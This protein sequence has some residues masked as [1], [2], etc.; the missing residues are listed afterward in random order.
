[1]LLD[2]GDGSEPQVWT[3]HQ[4][5]YDECVR[6]VTEKGPKLGIRSKLRDRGPLPDKV[7]FL[8]LR[9]HQ[10]ELKG[11]YQMRLFGFNKLSQSNHT[12]N[13]TVTSIP[14]TPPILYLKDRAT[15]FWEP[16]TIWR[17]MELRVESVCKLVCNST[18]YTE[19]FWTGIGI[20]EEWGYELDKVDMNGWDCRTKSILTVPP[21]TLNYGTYRFTY[22]VRITGDPTDP[23]DVSQPFVRSVDTFV[24]ITRSPLVVMMNKGGVSM[25]TLG[26]NQTIVINPGEFSYDPDWPSDKAFIFEWYC[27]RI[28]PDNETIPRD[29]RNFPIT[30]Q[31]SNPIMSP[32]DIYEYYFDN[33]TNTSVPV[34]KTD[35]GGCFGEGPGR[36]NIT[37]GLLELNTMQLR[38]TNC[39]YRFCAVMYK[40]FPAVR[41]E[42]QWDREPR[43]AEGCMNVGVVPGSP[44]LVEIKCQVPK[45]CRVTDRGTIINPNSRV[46]L[47]GSC[48]DLC[49][50]NLL[51]S[52]KIYAVRGGVPERIENDVDY[53]IGHTKPNMVIIKQ[54]FLDFP[55]VLEFHIKMNVVRVM[56]S[57]VGVGTMFLLINTPPEG[58]TCTLTPPPNRVL[59]VDETTP[60]DPETGFLLRHGRTLTEDFYCECKDFYDQQKDK[61]AKYSFFLKNNEWGY[62]KNLKFGIDNKDKFVFPLGNWTF[63]VT[64]E[65][66]FGAARNYFIAGFSTSLPSRLEYEAWTDKKEILRASGEGDQARL[67]QLLQARTSIKGFVLEDEP[68]ETTTT[69]PEPTYAPDEFFE[70]TTMDPE[71]LARIRAEQEAKLN[72]ELTE[73]AQEI[74]SMMTQLEM[75]NTDTL[76]DCTQLFS[77]VSSIVGDGKTVDIKGKDLA[78]QQVWCI[79]VWDCVTGSCLTK[80]L[81]N[82]TISDPAEPE[83]FVSNSMQSISS[84]TAG[85]SDKVLEDNILPTDLKA[86]VEGEYSEY[87]NID[88]T[89]EELGITLEEDPVVEEEVLDDGL[90]DEQREI[91]NKKKLALKVQKYRAV[92]QVQKTL[93]AV[94]QMQ[95]KLLQVVFPGEEPIFVNT[96]DG[97]EMTMV[98]MEAKDLAGYQLWQ[99]GGVYEFPDICDILKEEKVE[100]GNCSSTETGNYTVGIQAVA[101]PVIVQSF[102]DGAKEKLS[103]TTKTMQIRLVQRISETEIE[104]IPVED[105]EPE[106]EIKI[107]VPRGGRKREGPKLTEPTFVDPNH[108]LELGVE[109]ESM[110]C[111]SFNVSRE[112]SSINVEITVQNPEANLVVFIRRLEMPTLTE[113]DLVV[114]LEDITRV[115]NV[116]EPRLEPYDPFGNDT[117]SYI[118]PLYD[119]YLEDEFVTNQTGLY[120][121]CLSEFANHTD[122]E[123]FWADSEAFNLTQANITKVWSTNYTVRMYTS[124]CL[125]FKEDTMSWDRN[126]CRVL[127]ANVTHTVC[128]CNHLTSFASGFFP[129]PNAIDFNKLLNM[130][131]ADNPTIII[132][133][134]AT[135]AVYIMLLIWGRFKDK[136]DLTKLGATPLPDND[137]RDKE[138]AATK[139]KVQ[140]IVSGEKAETEIRTFE[141]RERTIFKR[142]GVDIFVMAV[143]EAL[144][145]LQ[146]LR[147]WHDNSGKGAE[148]SWYV[149]YIIFRDVQT[150][151]K[152]E[153]IANRWFAV[154]HDDCK[155][156]RLIGVAGDAQQK[157]FKHLFDTKSHK[158]LYDGHLWFSVF[159]RPARSR[160]TR[161]Q[162]ITAC[163]AL[164]YLS[165]T[166]NAMFDGVVP[167]EPGTGSLKVGPF[168]MSPAAQ[169]IRVEGCC[170][171]YRDDSLHNRSVRDPTKAF[172]NPLFVY[173]VSVDVRSPVPSQIGVGLLSNLV[174]FPPTLIIIQ[175]FRKVSPKYKRVSRIQ[176]AMDKQRAEKKREAEERL[177]WRR[178]RGEGDPQLQAESGEVGDR[179]GSRPKP[180]ITKKKRKELPW[181][182][183]YVAWLVAILS[184]GAGGFFT[185]AYGVTFGE[186]K[187]AKWLSSLFVSF[188]TSVLLTQPIKVFIMAMIFSA[189]CKSPNEEEDDA[190]NDE[191]DPELGED[192]EWMHALGTSSLLRCVLRVSVREERVKKKAEYKPV[193]EKQ[194]KAARDQRKKE[195]KMWDIIYDIGAYSFF[196]W[197]VLILSHGNRDPNSFLMTEELTN[198]FVLA[199]L[200]TYS[201]DINLYDVQNCSYFYH[202]MKVVFLE[203]I[204][205]NDNYH[206][207]LEPKH[208][209]TKMLHDRVNLLLGYATLR[210]VRIE[211]KTCKVPKQ[212]RSVTNE[213]RDKSSIVDEEKRDF[214]VGWKPLPERKRPQEEYTYRG[215]LELEGVPFWGSVDVYGAGGYV[216][217]LIGSKEKLKAKIEQLERDGWMDER[218]R[219]VFVEF[220]LYNA[221]VNLFAACRIVMEQGPEGAL[222]AFVKF[223]PIKLLRYSEG[224]GLFVMICEGVFILFIVYYTYCELKGMCR[225]KRQYWN[226]PWNYLELVVVGL[227]WSAIAFYGI[228]TVLGVSIVNKFKETGGSGYIKLEYAASIDEIFLYIISFMVFFSTLKFIKLLKFNKR[229]GLLTSTLKQ[230]ASDLSGFMIAFLLSFLAFAQLFYLMH[231]GSHIDFNNFVSAVEATFAAMLGKFDYEGMVNSSPKLGPITFFIFAFFNSIIMINLL[232]TL[233]IR[234]FEEIKNNLLK[235]SNEY[236]IVDFMMN[237]ARAAVGLAPKISFVGPLKATT[238][239]PEETPKTT[240][241][242]P[243]KVDQLLSYINDFY[244]ESKLDFNNKEWLKQISTV[245]KKIT[246]EHPPDS[247]QVGTVKAPLP[248]KGRRQAKETPPCVPQLSSWTKSK[249]VAENKS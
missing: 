54:L 157:E 93:S 248:V 79:G 100:T 205:M 88:A 242:F 150:G 89:L 173:C 224:F 221:Q 189:I 37:G 204:L 78:T 39:T 147:I 80:V 94:E 144:G 151:Q 46:A 213:C 20:D 53:M 202:W 84:M 208:D 196:I 222:H 236:E 109:D 38:A 132:T 36:I 240:E 28:A 182:M 51:F 83:A 164:L 135:L 229:M 98:M 56:D 95:T 214:D 67:N 203:E 105:L 185:F 238:E 27:Y 7:N 216:V 34:E 32:D 3:S 211:E 102:G 174:T 17:S 183:L 2:Y 176:K 125:F 18:L 70:T 235:Q 159:A 104:V 97:L 42:G 195:I 206:G 44:P 6:F 194:L 115:R 209:N 87:E 45:M 33:A 126:G 82:M 12:V 244:F 168:A 154:E 237:K 226:D 113:Y 186:E 29:K 149:R 197:I 91:Q 4:L 239:E 99:G 161:V 177:K 215:A 192:E 249:L 14:C 141:D 190:E 175:L 72:E 160:F 246:V 119:V 184:I 62:I 55:D 61:I 117:N 181:W 77:T 131:A 59:I 22:T 103:R 21:L 71:E 57:E 15:L 9:D 108:Y 112:W 85:T 156:D 219:A 30:D 169:S 31:I 16:K 25:I 247:I 231:N 230:C 241:E 170:E 52:F 227:G 129:Q 198:N 228:R 143:P 116:T 120:Y 210:Q 134:I 167:E 41:N 234:S 64:I 180:K 136:E 60:I 58:G 92:T 217:K 8:E 188:F 96:E 49:W 137:P 101:W 127:T 35:F 152:Y 243:E 148:A 225:D 163:M 121:V 187:T 90:T 110:L 10:Y 233:V 118:F 199:S 201:P 47:M 1:M 68:W 193:D 245:R 165:M 124:S 75:I 81:L 19:K 232:L 24:R 191:R 207:R 69:T 146:F 200:E 172:R 158:N 142:N 123:G 65:D 106:H 130:N 48:A 140:F 162:R 114:N 74:N 153:F 139:S 107:Y 155:I 223:N 179:K 218:T 73:S 13:A 63:W 145:N 11:Y 66:E 50:G 76:S 166:A 122:E 178:L 40:E 220:S 171:S 128:S 43:K 5:G 111:S 86:S 212:I 26:F 23:L 133:M 138:E